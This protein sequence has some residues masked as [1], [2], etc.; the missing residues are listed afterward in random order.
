MKLLRAALVIAAFTFGAIAATA[1]VAGTQAPYLV[2][3]DPNK[4]LPLLS[5]QTDEKGLISTFGATNVKAQTVN[6]DEGD[7]RPGTVIY[8]SKPQ[9][10]ASIVWKDPKKRQAAEIIR[11]EDQPS[12]WRLPN[13][14]STGTTLL[15]LEKLNGKPFKLAGFDW[16]Y[17][18][19]VNSWNGGKLEKE[20]TS[21][22]G[23]V[24]VALRLSPSAGQSTP[25][26]LEGDSE[27]SSSDPRMRKLN[28]KVYVMMILNP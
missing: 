11:I 1:Q 2:M 4:I 21:K 24:S 15:E 23:K 8:P 22:S 17:S 6:L 16:C 9:W 3:K 5:A 26:G 18:G 13:G 10:R 25:A 7:S 19:S 28:P 12:S 27:F 20:L 14:I